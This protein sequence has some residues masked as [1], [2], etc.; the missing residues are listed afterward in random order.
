MRFLIL[1]PLEA[2]D[3]GGPV[4]LGG[5]QQRAVLAILLLHVNEVVSRDRLIEGL[6]G[7]APPKSAGHTLESYISRL[8]K[9]LG[10]N[11]NEAELLTRPHGYS[12]NADAEQIDAHLFEDLVADGRRQLAAGAPHEAASSL[13]EAL[14]LFRGPPLD[15]LAFFPFARAAAQ[16]LEE[17]RLA[18][19]QDR[20]E[21]DLESGRDSDLIPE[22][23]ALAEEHPLVERIHGQLMLALYRA[24]RQAEALDVYRTLRR[25]LVDE[26][27]I[28][29]GS[30]I[31][32][33]HEAILRQDRLDVA[34]RESSS[35]A[36]GRERSRAALRPRGFS[37]LRF[38]TVITIGV[39]ATGAVAAILA[40]IGGGTSGAEL[41][42]G[43]SVA[44]LDPAQGGLVG[45]VGLDGPPGQAVRGAGALWV[46]LFED[47]SVARVDPDTKRVE[48][49]IAVGSGPSAMAFGSDA[50]WVA[51]S[52]D[53]TVSRIDPTTNRVVDTIPV[54]NGP[55][56]LAFGDGSL[57]VANARANEIAELEGVSGEVTRRIPLPA[58]P[59]G[60][61]FASGALWASSQSVGSVFR[62]AARSN[63]VAEIHVGTGP[64]GIAAGDGA[65]WVA[66]TLDG[67]VSRIDP[68]RGAVT[69]T[70]PVGNGPL[71]VDVASGSVWVANEFDGT[72]SRIDAR[73][74]EVTQTIAVGEQ[75][76]G[77]AAGTGDISIPIQATS[78]GHRGGTLRI[79][80]SPPSFDTVD[81]AIHNFLSPAQLLGMT[82]DG[83]V[84]LKHVGGSTGDQLVPDLALT[85]PTPTD[86]GRTY[87]FQLRGGIRYSTGAV[88]RPIDFRRAIERDF[89]LGSPGA[90]FYLGLVGG[91]RCAHRPSQCDLSEGIE[92]DDAANTVT[93]RLVEPDPDFLYK[94]IPPYAAAVP[95]G[96]SAQDV[97]RK[98]VP[99][100]GPYM[101]DRYVPGREL[102]L[103]RNPYFRE[104]SHAARPDGFVD[105]IVF[106]LGIDP[107][108]AVTEVENG[109]ADT[110]IYEVPYAPPGDRLH[111]LLTRYSAQVHINPLPELHYFIMNTRE[112]PFD[113]VRV[114]RALNYAIDRNVLVDL[115]GGPEL[116][117]PTCQVLP[118]SI[119]GHKPYCPYTVNRSP[120]GTYS[121]P[122]LAKARRL[123]AASGTRGMRVTV[124]TD[125]HLPDT[126]YVV[127]VLRTLGY[128]VSARP[129]AGQR[130]NRV[131]SNTRNRTQISVGGTLTDY[132]APSNI[133]QTWLSC[134][135]FRPNSDLNHNRAGFCD[136][137][138]DTGIA[139]ALGLETASPQA[140]HR[141]WARVDRTVVDQAPWLPT[142]NLNTVDFVSKRV[143]NYQFNPQWGLLLDQ[144][145]VR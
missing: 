19:L 52:L 23:Y 136:P 18:A 46:S 103:V 98:A 79:A 30:S 63:D 44:I 91:R 29:P 28:E 118:P 74:G 42:T 5:P 121:G 65:V 126:R 75:P 55:S 109:Q 94:L 130:Y 77:V 31:R 106:R 145:W 85:L 60:V 1:G 9:A 58:A 122:D 35:A 33:L 102:R 56:S 142:V 70:L 24:G 114:R 8:R 128:R 96:V 20:I 127:S 54:G 50:L 4:A 71:A 59:T 139:R 113:D 26:L 57:W 69:T 90:I 67:T 104:W 76:Q 81:P 36:A 144:V 87:R 82:N 22:L 84:T 89:E 47:H 86:A 38:A 53:G 80:A 43:D 41:A 78:A 49:T 2:R 132:P 15:D 64:A 14:G 140:A 129:V 48:E 17:A 37:R 3:G 143:G 100:T 92:V 101:I 72:L 105:R 95:A 25:T 51:N 88:L 39:L 125:P 12:L 40:V 34:N 99:A 131:A 6:W 117:R 123:V 13:E 73:E 119:E 97:G 107:D 141:Q 11:G 108:R 120:A 124:V 68:S 133:I 110:G 137:A 135:S 93:F 115:N 32:E 21:A 66:N 83:L 7:E 27:G 116:A 45:E 112:P 62:I 16:H 138:V 61:A 10:A 134:E 111:E